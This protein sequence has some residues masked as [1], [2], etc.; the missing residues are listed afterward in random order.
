MYNLHQND[1]NTDPDNI[2]PG[3]GIFAAI[4]I[5]GFIFCTF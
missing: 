5:F 4:I 2:G 3:L 1:Y